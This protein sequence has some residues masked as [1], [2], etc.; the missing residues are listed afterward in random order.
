[1]NSHQRHLKPVAAKSAGSHQR[2]MVRGGQEKVIFTKGKWERIPRVTARLVAFM[3]L[4]VGLRRMLLCTIFI[5]TGHSELIPGWT[6]EWHIPDYVSP[7]P[8]QRKWSL[9]LAT[10]STLSPNWLH[11]FGRAIDWIIFCDQ[12]TIHHVPCLYFLWG[13]NSCLMRA[14]VVTQ[15]INCQFLTLWPLLFSR[16]QSVGDPE[17]ALCP[18]PRPGRD[19]RVNR[20][21]KCAVKWELR[22]SVRKPRRQWMFSLVMMWQSPWWWSARSHLLRTSDVE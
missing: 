20:R 17:C 9:V 1:M 14:P 2:T 3:R 5:G 22:R 7:Q 4:T 10:P 8:N 13:A 6:R 18:P 16:K 11:L 12:L 19:R 21:L 15:I